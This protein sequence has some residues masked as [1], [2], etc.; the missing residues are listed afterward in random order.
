M[1]MVGVYYDSLLTGAFRAQSL[2][3]VV[4]PWHSCFTLFG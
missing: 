1:M 3:V 4:F 2:E